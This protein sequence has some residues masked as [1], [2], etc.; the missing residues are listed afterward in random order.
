MSSTSFPEPVQRAS[1]EHVVRSSNSSGDGRNALDSDSG[2]LNCD[3]FPPII[4]R[5]FA[6]FE[7]PP[8]PD[9][10]QIFDQNEDTIAVRRGTKSMHVE[11]SL[12]GASESVPSSSGSSPF[13]PSGEA[14]S[15]H[16]ETNMHGASVPVSSS[17]GSSPFL[18]SRGPISAENGLPM[19]SR[20]ILRAF[21][22]G[23]GLVS[24]PKKKRR[25]K[26]SKPAKVKNSKPSDA[27]ASDPILKQVDQLQL[28]W[29]YDMT[30]TKELYPK[31]K[32]VKRKGRSTR[33]VEERQ[34]F[35]E[36]DP[37]EDREYAK[38][39]KARRKAW[40]QKQAEREK[41]RRQRQ[42]E[43]EK[44]RKEREAEE[45]KLEKA[46]LKAE[47]AAKKRWNGNPF[48]FGKGNDTPRSSLG[49]QEHNLKSRS[50]TSLNSEESS[51]GAPRSS[52]PL[53]SVL[54][55]VAS[56]IPSPPSPMSSTAAT[57]KMYAAR[58]SQR[59]SSV[60]VDSKTRLLSSYDT[61]RS[62]LTT[63][64]AN[65]SD[66]S[67]GSEMF[68][69]TPIQS[70]DHGDNMKLSP[71]QVKPSSGDKKIMTLPSTEPSSST[72]NLDNGSAKIG[73]MTSSAS[74]KVKKGTTEKGVVTSPSPTEPKSIMEHDPEKANA[75]NKHKKMTFLSKSKVAKDENTQ[76]RGENS[77]KRN[78]V[79]VLD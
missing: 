8:V 17:K 61:A 14:S 69:A 49:S 32:V 70:E 75:A 20:A 77:G 62:H 65:D 78:G 67:G 76:D 74:E 30:S 39:E 34:V 63:F 68:A 3:T 55:R 41:V 56:A 59:G 60:T 2:S 4:L 54:R 46:E 72:S 11:T 48:A 42:A 51:S 36:Y 16:V 10:E 73:L 5:D 35:G 27:T 21:Y 43:K 23:E 53:K 38:D 44:A 12:H 50:A 64:S 47:K 18:P 31:V 19:T 52:S 37:T 40:R 26:Q 66:N 25:T 1:E 24:P 29:G 13:L 9:W 33:I 22:T 79:K 15:M 45:K 28:E 71:T 57:Y 58:E 7:Q 6:V